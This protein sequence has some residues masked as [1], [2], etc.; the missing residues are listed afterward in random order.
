MED[1]DDSRVNNESQPQPQPQL[2][3]P[4]IEDT[5]IV[6]YLDIVRSEYEI[7]R[8]KKQSFEDRAGLVMALAGALCIFL[9]ENYNGVW[10][11]SRFY[12]HDDYVN[13][14]DKCKKA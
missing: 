6:E 11:L 4:R 8:A 3:V 13:K 10:R 9:F 1:Q 2:Q 12:V 14:N 7:E 5:A